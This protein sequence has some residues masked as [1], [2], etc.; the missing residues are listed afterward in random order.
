MRRKL[1]VTTFIVLT[2]LSGCN[3]NDDQESQL[4]IGEIDGKRKLWQQWK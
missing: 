1:L 4:R 3:N 2:A